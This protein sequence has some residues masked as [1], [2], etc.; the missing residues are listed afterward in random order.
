MAFDRLPP[1]ART[2]SGWTSCSYFLYIDIP[3]SLLGV[4]GI[5]SAAPAGAFT[6]R[7]AARHRA[8]GMS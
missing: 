5:S 8:I 3:D 4:V 6:L 7:D 2:V 1:V